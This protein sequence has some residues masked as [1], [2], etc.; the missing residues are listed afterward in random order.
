MQNITNFGRVAVGFG[1]HEDH[2]DESKE[3]FRS[4]RGKTIHHIELPDDFEKPVLIKIQFE[5]L[6]ECDFLDSEESHPLLCIDIFSFKL[7][8]FFWLQIRINGSLIL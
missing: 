5:E 6:A 2:H 8:R 7:I 1:E 3:R 4:Q